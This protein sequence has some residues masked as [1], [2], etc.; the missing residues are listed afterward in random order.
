MTHFHTHTHTHTHHNHL[1]KERNSS[2]TLIELL[3]VIAIIGILAAIILISLASVN[4]RVSNQSRVGQA[5]QIQKA[6]EQ[7]YIANGAYPLRGNNAWY[8]FRPG[9]ENCS[10]G[11]NTGNTTLMSDISPYLENSM[12]VIPASPDPNGCPSAEFYFSGDQTNNGQEAA[13]IDYRIFSSNHADCTLGQYA[14]N[15]GTCGGYYAEYCRIYLN[16]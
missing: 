9:T 1:L 13:A 5:N 15:D 14:G 11:G 4:V 8:C 10:N 16:Y 2:F 12:T 6:L 3:I 7:Y